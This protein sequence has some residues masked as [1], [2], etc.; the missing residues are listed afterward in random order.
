MTEPEV[1]MIDV[2]NKTI[3]LREAEAEGFI[4]LKKETI[5][6]IIENEIEKG[7]VISIAKTAGILAAKKTSELIPLCHLIP[8]ENV[9]IDIKIEDE[10]LRVISKVKAHYKTGVEMEA[11]VATAI[12]LLTIWDMVKKYEKDDKGQYPY[13]L[14]K[15]IKVINKIKHV[16]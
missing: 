13:T 7:N 1:R 15:E 3:T 5:Q 12:A 14:I 16:T 11:L 2:S 9:E 4:K 8:L 6:K 10:G